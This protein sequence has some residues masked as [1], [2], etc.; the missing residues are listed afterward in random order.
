MTFE[1]VSDIVNM[2]IVS[3]YLI[4]VLLTRL[5]FRLQ[6]TTDIDVTTGSRVYQ[7]LGMSEIDDCG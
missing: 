6:L 2:L 7:L 3:L 1:T 4:A 5:L